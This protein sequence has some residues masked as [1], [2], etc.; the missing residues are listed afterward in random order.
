M[1]H[2]D[3]FNDLFVLELA[4]NHWGRVERGLKIIEDF[5]PYV[6]QYGIKASIK[7]QI[8]DV[9]KFIHKD[10]L[11]R[12]DI[13][14]IKKT[15]DTKLSREHMATLVQAVKSHGLIPMATAFDEASVDLCMELG[16]EVLKI[17]SSDLSDKI[18]INKIIKMN[19]PTI[20][21]T[22]GS[23]LADIDHLVER[24][25]KAN[26][27]LAVNHCVSLYPSEDRE[28]EIN[29]VDFLVNRYPNNVIGFS[30][31]EYHD[32]SSSVMIAYAKGART[33]ERHIDI[34]ADGIPVSPYCT[35][36]HQAGEWFKAFRKAQEMC[37][38]PSHVKRVPP[39]R[40]VEYLD[41]LVRGTYAKRDLPVGHTLS[42][43]DVYFA[44]P[45]QQGQISSREFSA[46]EVLASPVI[47]DAPLLINELNCHYKTDEVV[48]KI[49]KRGLAR[50]LG[51]S[52]AAKRAIG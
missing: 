20:V 52:P 42:H 23:Q 10:F 35:L 11:H 17:A 38:G 51:A 16:I 45:L 2:H 36:P 7:L 47:A 33:F 43:D 9:E 6:K 39:Q 34:E 40:E 3:L 14:Y 48:E 1:Q 15:R 25:A 18:L 28:L 41:A 24:F 27:P 26:I 50:E 30:T 46:G 22:G 44:V 21:S 49:A 37:G 13:R 8:R 4:N 29:Q 12:D 19:V 5:A 32:W 31:H